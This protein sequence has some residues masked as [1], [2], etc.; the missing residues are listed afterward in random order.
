MTSLERFQATL[1]G[2]TADRIPVIT[3]AFGCAAVSAGI[4][5]PLYYQG[6]SPLADA[7]LHALRRFGSDA[8]F[9][10]ADAN[11]E[12]EAMGGRMEFPSDSY[13]YLRQP[14]FSPSEDPEGLRHP[15]PAADGRM[16][17]ILK[18][19]RLLRQAVGETTPIIGI[20]CG[21]LTLLAQ[22]LGLENALVLAIEDTPR[23]LG[24]LRQAETVCA[25]WGAAQLDAG[26]HLVYVFDPAA[27]PSVVPSAFFREFE[28]PA[29]ERI[30]ARLES[31][32]NLC[33]SLHITG[34]IEPILPHY[35]AIGVELANFDYEVDILRIAPELP[36]LAI[37]GNIR[38]LLLQEADPSLLRGQCEELLEALGE[39][40]RFILSPGCE[41][42]LQTRPD[43][44]LIFCSSVRR[45]TKSAK[46]E[47]RNRLTVT[48]EGSET[49]LLEKAPVAFGEPL[50]EALRRLD[51]PIL[52]GC[53]GLGVCGRCEI[54]ILEGRPP[55]P[56]SADR[57]HFNDCELE[58]GFRLACQTYLHDSLSV[59]LSESIR[60]SKWH[61]L[62]ERKIAVYPPG[63]GPASTSFRKKG[64][65]LVLDL[66]TS[67]LELSG[68]GP[69]AALERIL[70]H[71]NPQADFGSDIISRAQAAVAHPRALDE[72][73]KSLAAALHKGCLELGADPLDESHPF[74]LTVAGNTVMLCLFAGEAFEATL[75]PANWTRPILPAL[76]EDD[77]FW[78]E[79]L[80]AARL[81]LLT[82]VGGF[83]GSDLMAGLLATDLAGSADPALFVDFGT[84]SEVA[85]W[86]GSALWIASAAGGPAFEGCG[87]AH[88][89]PAGPGAIRNCRIDPSGRVH[90]T[91]IGNARPSGFCTTGVIDL[92]ASFLRN[93]WID[94]KGEVLRHPNLD[95]PFHWRLEKPDLDHLQR[96]KAGIGAT[97]DLLLDR[98]SLRPG[99]LARICL[100]GQVGES[101]DSR[102]ARELG[103]VPFVDPDRIEGVP[104]APLIG[105]ARWT[106]SAE[107]RAEASRLASEAILVSPALEED[108]EERFI[109]HL[110]LRP[111]HSSPHPAP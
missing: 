99:Q 30:L 73:R 24:F 6:G 104:H 10:F 71:A 21:P 31:A 54:R 107:V 111:M 65:A 92:V 51:R 12:T 70:V 13:P 64:G 72:M 96:A 78:R 55:E 39:R 25:T 22:W 5:L 27:S 93:G 29:L 106:T 19:T 85:L 1:R 59:Q 53:A 17:G 68:I 8:V 16:P 83:V 80:P 81:E 102:S 41:A 52:L 87:L 103:V 100:A 67:R 57:I 14:P 95:L 47:E 69:D 3:Q 56:S 101:I 37:N 62:P 9:T 66:G 42:P 36:R 63:W 46:G 79:A 97:I 35:E 32:G 23:F 86:T 82:P 108:F 75:A 44:L 15:R 90:P 40:G 84:N 7:Q 94:P 61:E 109:E 48:R 43:N 20:T 58:E 60:E 88:V 33:R 28:A 105:A 11:V 91:T 98:A 49:L 2:R 4:D 34:P 89:V 50:A 77:P 26:A 76:R 110:Y 38:P 18:A 74:R 45:K